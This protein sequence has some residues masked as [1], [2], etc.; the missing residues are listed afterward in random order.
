MNTEL[1]PG[2]MALVIGATSCTDNIGKIVEVDCFVKAGDKLPSG[3]SA[4]IDCIVAYGDCL[5]VFRPVSMV[6]ESRDYGLFLASQLMPVNPEADP[7]Q[8]K[9]EQH[10][11][12]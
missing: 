1:K 9:E 5:V 11:S 12:A 10:A 6:Y 8:A 7:L 2:M 4:G 3:N